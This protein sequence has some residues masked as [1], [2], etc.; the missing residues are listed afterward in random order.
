MHVISGDDDL[1]I[2]EVATRSNVAIEISPEART[3]SAPKKTWGDWFIQ[4]RRHLTTAPL[5]PSSTRSFL[6]M[7]PISTALFYLLL[8]GL[9]VFLYNWPVLIAIFLLRL[10]IMLGV[11]GKCAKKLGEKPLIG[12]IPFLDVVMLFVY[13]AISLSKLFTRK[14]KW[15]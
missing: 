10:G 2:Q 14:N 8:A 6:G 3:Y 5:Y 11:L 1:F 12:L 13:P 4:K 9:A 7:Y 15:S